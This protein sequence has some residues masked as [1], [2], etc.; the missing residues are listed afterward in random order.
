[1]FVEANSIIVGLKKGGIIHPVDEYIF[2]EELHDKYDYCESFKVI[3]KYFETYK[4]KGSNIEKVIV[5]VDEL[6]P[7]LLELVS[8]C[9]CRGWDLYLKYYDPACNEDRDHAVLS[10]NMKEL[11]GKE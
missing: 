6:T 5:Y 9:Y 11:Y 7:A 3:D 10:N 1:M 8:Y 4:N 2:T